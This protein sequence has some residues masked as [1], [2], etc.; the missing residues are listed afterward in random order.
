MPLK[1]RT[2]V[3]AAGQIVVQGNTTGLTITSG[4][5]QV[6]PT[7]TDGAITFP[8]LTTDDVDYITLELPL[9]QF[10]ELY[11]N[12]SLNITNTGLSLR[13]NRSIPLFMSGIYYD[14][15]VQNIT[16]PAASS[17]T[18]TYYVYVNLELGTP[19]YFISSTEGVE[20]EITMFIG[21]IN[22]STTTITSININ[23]VSRFG[24]Y[25]P[26][27]TNKGS[28]FPVSTGHPAQT[29]TINW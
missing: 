26:S 20:N 4:N 9:S 3:N 28:S 8:V 17:G 21:T 19:G 12:T 5:G 2:D 23:K 1:Y 24:T 16:V 13:F 15:P 27:T 10:G 6:Y 22:V 7:T 11:E 29:G 18:M 25:R 14:V